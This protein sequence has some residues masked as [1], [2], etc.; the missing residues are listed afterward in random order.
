MATRL[1]KEFLAEELRSL[2]PGGVSVG[3]CLKITRR[4]RPISTRGKKPSE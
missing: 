4:R 2:G 3:L 1:T